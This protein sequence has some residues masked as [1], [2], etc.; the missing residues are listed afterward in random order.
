MNSRVRRAT[1]V[2]AGLLL[3][4]K[5]A[6][7]QFSFGFGPSLPVGD[8]ADEAVR[9]YHV[10]G[11]V[12]FSV[13]VL[14]F[15]LRTDLFFQNHSNVER[16]P[17]LSVSLGG[18]WFRTFGLML[19]ATYDLDLGNVEPYAVVGAGWVR[20]WHGDRSHWPSSHTAFNLNGGVGVN[21]PLNDRVSLFV[22][23]RQLNVA[24]SALP[25]RAPAINEEVQFRSI[26]ITLGVS[27]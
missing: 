6:T 19:N 2:A 1:M 22:E 7:A 13:P 14:P 17:G 4:P 3:I 18:E 15:G 12:A 5:L 16:A 8:F 23:A 11:S 27:F 21:V 10:Q 26:P 9:G 24:G 20:E 25:L